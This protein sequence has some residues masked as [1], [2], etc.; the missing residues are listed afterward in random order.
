MI[1]AYVLASPRVALRPLP[2][3]CR[4]PTRIPIFLHA[5]V[6]LQAVPEQEERLEG[7]SGCLSPERLASN[8][9][10]ARDGGDAQPEVCAEERRRVPLSPVLGARGAR[11]RG[12]P[13]GWPRV[14]G[15][16]A[17][18]RRVEGPRA[19]SPPPRVGHRAPTAFPARC[20]FWSK[21]AGAHARDRQGR[22]ALPWAL[23]TRRSATIPS[24][25]AKVRGGPFPSAPCPGAGGRRCPDRA[26]VASRNGSEGGAPTRKRH[27][28]CAD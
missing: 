25:D 26:S 11:R 23:E 8:E 6:L 15:H 9:V 28:R 17:P 21:S 1:S 22:G 20:D 27:A 18:P 4:R 2:V 7:V 12:L 16:A 24:G 13:G 5:S 10:T 19:A 3:C 14:G